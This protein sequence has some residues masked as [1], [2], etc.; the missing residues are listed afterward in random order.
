MNKFFRQKRE[1]EQFRT[2]FF[3]RS[4]LFSK[5]GHRVKPW[6]VYHAPLMNNL[7]DLP[8]AHWT[9]L[10]ENLMKEAPLVDLS[11]NLLAG[12]SF[13]QELIPEEV[14]FGADSWA[15]LEPVWLNLNF[16]FC[17]PVALTLQVKDYKILNSLETKLKFDSAFDDL[18]VK[19]KE[20]Q[21]QW[22]NLYNDYCQTHPY[23]KLTL[24]DEF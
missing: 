22:Q 9:G 11:K 2:R 18:E 16:S 1:E 7:I 4:C 19:V 23:L 21:T 20:T 24:W 6:R 3:F 12:F 5:Q 15:K 10:N 14:S 8:A 17:F 13:N